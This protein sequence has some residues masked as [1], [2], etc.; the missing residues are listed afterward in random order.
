MSIGS[1]NYKEINTV[2][3]YVAVTNI[4]L[5]CNNLNEPVNIYIIISVLINV[6]I[7]MF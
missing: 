1:F 7:F 4:C 5:N 6:H 2:M 3:R